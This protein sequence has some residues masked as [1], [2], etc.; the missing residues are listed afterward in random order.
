M[1]VPQ[2]AGAVMATGLASDARSLDALKR[3]AAKD[4]QGAVRQ[5]AS[6]FEAVFMNMLLKSMRDSLPRED[7]LGSDSTRMY[8]GMLDDQLSQG[9]S[10][11]G[12]GL[13]D[14]MVDRKSTRLNSSH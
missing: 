13:A 4:P 7:M 14:L 9:L 2:S 11:K 3:S 5:A 8:T 12:L 6:Q 10:G 1:S